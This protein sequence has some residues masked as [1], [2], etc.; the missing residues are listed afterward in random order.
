MI[1][2]I[3]LP[4]TSAFLEARPHIDQLIDS[5]TGSLVP[6]GR[7]VG[8]LR[9]YLYSTTQDTP[10]HALVMSGGEALGLIPRWTRR[11]NPRHVILGLG[12]FNGPLVIGRNRTLALLGL[13]RS[14]VADTSSWD[15]LLAA[16]D[17]RSGDLRRLE[18]AARCEKLPV[19]TVPTAHGGV[20]VVPSS[21]A[22]RARWHVSTA[23]DDSLT[24]R[25]SLIE[26]GGV[27]AQPKS[28]LQDAI[29]VLRVVFDPS[30]DEE[31][32]SDI[33]TTE[34]P[35]SSEDSRA[36]HLP[37]ATRPPLRVVRPS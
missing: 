33:P 14:F 3:L 8:L 6:I 34:I 16:G 1:S 20:L 11:T 27:I 29:P 10:Q 19:R 26:I 5:H 17:V 9:D 2:T 35:P 18:T 13:V 28:V 31:S 30:L 22:L 4:T 24:K 12:A 7:D 15:V 21:S 23:S 36:A 32:L 37:P 25:W